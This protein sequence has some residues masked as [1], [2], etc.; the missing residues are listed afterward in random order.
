MMKRR[1]ICL[2]LLLSGILTGYAFGRESPKLASTFENGQL[3]KQDNIY[4]LKLKGDYLQRGRQYGKL[5]NAHVK[6]MYEIAVEKDLI[7]EGIYSLERLKELTFR[8]IWPAT[9]LP[10]LI[11]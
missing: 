3:L 4:I 11:F 9:P 5:L 1:F 2:I 8:I 7:E 6:K 10:G